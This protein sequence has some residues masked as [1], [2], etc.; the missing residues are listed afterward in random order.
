LSATKDRY[1][2]S[3]YGPVGQG[4]IGVGNPVAV[5]PGPPPAQVRIYIQGTN[6]IILDNNTGNAYA[7]PLA[8]ALSAQPAVYSPTK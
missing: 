8:T 3:G 2:G 6:L 5:T 4:T 7:V 1:N